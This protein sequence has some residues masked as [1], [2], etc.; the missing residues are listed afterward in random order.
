MQIDRQIVS[1]RR[2]SSSDRD[3]PALRQTD[4]NGYIYL[5][6]ACFQALSAASKRTDQSEA[7]RLLPRVTY[8]ALL[9]QRLPNGLVLHSFTIYRLAEVPP[10]CWTP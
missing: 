8:I 7:R 1:V 10:Y 9:E 6:L 5:T 4:V 3:G 2:R